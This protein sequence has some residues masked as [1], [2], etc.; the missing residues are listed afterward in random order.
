MASSTPSTAGSSTASQHA[1]GRVRGRQ[2]RPTS[3]PSRGAPRAGTPR[4]RLRLPSPGPTPMRAPGMGRWSMRSPPMVRF[5]A[6]VGAPRRLT[7]AR[8][9]ARAPPDPS[10][11]H[12]RDRRY[13]SQ[14]SRARPPDDLRLYVPD[15]R[16][17]K[18]VREATQRHRPPGG[19]WETRYAITQADRAHLR[20]RSCSYPTYGRRSAP[21]TRAVA[22]LKNISLRIL[23]SAAM[24]T[25]TEGAHGHHGPPGWHRHPPSPPEERGRAGPPAQ[26]AGMVEIR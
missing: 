18:A 19:P 21:S 6:R 25:V 15:A 12:R 22:L 23:L 3:S 5:H 9:L 14:A 10:H 7:A 24:D 4:R 2:R 1:L 26:Q 17:S 20:R 13:A 16:S 11:G 8:M